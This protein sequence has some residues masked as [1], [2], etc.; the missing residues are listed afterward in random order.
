MA[1]TTRINIFNN[2]Y[3]E[4]ILKKN[5]LR[6]W[7]HVI[8]IMSYCYCNFYTKIDIKHKDKINLLYVLFKESLSAVTPKYTADSMSAYV[9]DDTIILIFVIL[10]NN[11]FKFFLCQC[12]ESIIHYEYKNYRVNDIHR[13]FK[14]AETI[15]GSNEKYA[16]MLAD[17]FEINDDSIY[18]IPIDLKKFTLNEELS[19]KKSSQLPTAIIQQDIRTANKIILHSLV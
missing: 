3:I 11:V 19:I 7:C 12:Y 16:C 4:K 8:K 18:R 14:Y 13:F 15:V 1:W 5:P 6:T 9:K 17:D 2:I 10:H